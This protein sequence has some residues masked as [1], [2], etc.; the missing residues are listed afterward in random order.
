MQWQPLTGRR[1]GRWLLASA[2][3]VMASV[4]HGADDSALARAMRQ[5]RNLPGNLQ[6]ITQL[7]EV[8]FPVGTAALP[9]GTGY[10]LPEPGNNPLPS[11]E[12]VYSATPVPPEATD[13][14]FDLRQTFRGE[15]VRA[16]G[17]AGKGMNRSQFQQVAASGR[18]PI[19]GNPDTVYGEHDRNG[20][21]ILSIAEFTPT[22][23]EIANTCDVA[24]IT[25]DFLHNRPYGSGGTQ[26]QTQ[27][28]NGQGNQ[29][30]NRNRNGQDSTAGGGNGTA[31]SGSS[32]ASGTDNGGN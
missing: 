7:F 25:D 12:P 10:G 1:M 29:N 18:V 13:A 31:G 5:L 11:P 19:K 15:F 9:S 8:F 28:Q 17:D 16:T 26:T 4:G 24:Q 3:L 32:L 22:P 30:R 27:N 14:I 20:D 23:A 2:F 21:G 6:S